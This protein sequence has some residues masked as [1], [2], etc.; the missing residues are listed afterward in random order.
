MRDSDLW[1][2]YDNDPE[3]QTFTVL[4]QT[5]IWSYVD[6]ESMSEYDLKDDIKSLSKERLLEDISDYEIEKATYENYDEIFDYSDEEYYKNKIKKL[7]IKIKLLEDKLNE[8]SDY[9]KNST[10]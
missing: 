5:R 7:E 1:Y 6:V 10:R 9:K 4:V 3:P 2:P 8:K